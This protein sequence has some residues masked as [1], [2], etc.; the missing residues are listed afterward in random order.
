MSFV[1]C[2]LSSRVFLSLSSLLTRL[3]ALSAP[4]IFSRLPWSEAPMIPFFYRGTLL[5]PTTLLAGTFC[6]LA[7]LVSLSFLLSGA[8]FIGLISLR[9]IF[10]CLSLV[11]WRFYQFCRRSS[12]RG[13]SLFSPL[14]L[15][16]S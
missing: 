6:S 4:F 1:W 3:V 9:Q 12:P 5:M 16:C 2:A 13:Y 11:S 10:Y 8:S 15:L 14:F 7:L